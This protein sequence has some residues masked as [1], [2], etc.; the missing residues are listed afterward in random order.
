MMIARA[1]P[2]KNFLKKRA[3][4]RYVPLLV[5]ALVFYATAPVYYH[6]EALAQNQTPTTQNNNAAAKDKSVATKVGNE[7]LVA[8]PTVSIAR[9]RGK[10]TNACDKV[11]EAKGGIL[12]GRIVPCIAKTIEK[13]TVT[14]SRKMITWLGPL[15]YSFM[16]LVMCLFGVK[17]LQGEQQL[18]GQG[19]MMLIKMGFVIMMFET[20]PY[21]WVNVSY[22]MINEGVD[23]VSETLGGRSQKLHCP[24][25]LKYGDGRTPMIWKQMD[26]VLGHLF[27]IAVGQ[28]G[29]PGMLM[30]SSAVGL[31]TG[32]FFGGSYGVAVFFALIGLLVSVA[33]MAL[34][35]GMAFLNGYLIVCLMWILAPLFLPLMMLKVTE[36]YYEKWWKLILS[37][38]LTPI[39]IAGYSMFA[40]LVYDGLFFKEDA[41]IPK[42]FDAKIIKDALQNAKAVGSN[43]IAVDPAVVAAENT[44]DEWFAEMLGKDNTY[45]TKHDALLKDVKQAEANL[46]GDRSSANLTK[47]TYANQKLETFKQDFKE[48]YFANNK[49]KQTEFEK[50]KQKNLERYLNNPFVKDGSGL[51][52]GSSNFLSNFKVPNFDLLKIND[53]LYNTYIPGSEAIQDKKILINLFMEAM[54]AFILAYLMGAGLTSVEGSIASIVGSQT[55]SAAINHRSAFEQKLQGAFDEG[56]NNLSRAFDT[57]K[58]DK[59]GNAVKD[60]DGR[61][62]QKAASGTEFLKRMRGATESTAK[63]MLGGMIRK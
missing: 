9:E 39:I 15:F 59:S 34:R 1:Q 17:L 52:T 10:T 58:L 5:A 60:E 21:Y 49:E 23:I 46:S 56:R 32:F 40:L 30:K 54:K 8:K 62:V 35:V 7:N 18:A 61:I 25:V 27:G 47:L 51:S 12:M 63:T 50:K 13:S 20:I 22:G 33:M 31:L 38:I 45:K 3:V 11:R 55:A 48:D 19:I 37:G 29:E 24:N 36:G 6:Y 44:E 4:A 53:P 14:M 16:S 28:N 57:D 41:M 26:C 43:P 42:L 2:W